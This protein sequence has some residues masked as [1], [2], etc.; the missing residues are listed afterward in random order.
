MAGQTSDLE[1]NHFCNSPRWFMDNARHYD[2][3]DRKLPPVYDGE[4]A[5]TSGEGGFCKAQTNQR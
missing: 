2:Y 4:V 3:R 1:D 5:V